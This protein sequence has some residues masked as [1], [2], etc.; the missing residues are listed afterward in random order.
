MPKPFDS[1]T[2]REDRYQEIHALAA[3]NGGNCLSTAYLNARTQYRWRCSMGHEWEASY[4]SVKR[5]SW[6]KHC[7]SKE[8]RSAYLLGLSVFR[9]LAQSRG[10]RCLSTVYEG[11]DHLLDWECANGHQWSATGGSVRNS[12]TWCPVCAGRQRGNIGEMQ[13]LAESRGGRCVSTEYLN[14]EAKLLWRCAN[15][16]EWWARAGSVKRGTWCGIC[17]RSRRSSK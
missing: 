11:K 10:G 15:G 12:G 4:D 9:E 1:N 13:V 8:A 2:S 7:R 17:Y 3:K 6:C 5:G 16:H 14:N